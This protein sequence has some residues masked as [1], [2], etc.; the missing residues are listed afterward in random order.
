ME[1]ENFPP[2][3]YSALGKKIMSIHFNKKSEISSFSVNDLNNFVGADRKLVINDSNSFWVHDILLIKHSKYFAELLGTNEKKPTKEEKVRINGTNIIKTYIDVP[4]PEYFFDILTW[5]Y[6]KDPYR[7]SNAADEPESFLS[8]LSLGIFL[9]LCDEFFNSILTTCEI[10][11]DDKLIQNSQWSRFCF[12]FEVL[13]KL[14]E[15]MPKNNYLLKLCAT[16]SW[17]K[18]DNTL[19]I[20]NE[21][22][23]IEER[24]LE[25]LTCKEFFMVKDYLKEHKFLD[26]IKMTDISI[27]KEKYPKLLPALDL[28]YLIKRYIEG[29]IIKISCK[30]CNKK[31][32][33]IAQFIN[34]PC[35][36]KMYHPRNFVFLQ[37]Q[38]GSKC[39]HEDCKKKMSINE[40]PC[41]HKASHVDGC[42]MSDGN[43]ML[44][45]E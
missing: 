44:I 27:I 45:F 10:Q 30:I 42:L 29:N 15:L 26:V 25:L 20:S 2:Q 22:D 1:E 6:S 38:L 16:L 19:N 35:D 8:I 32:N 4:H 28:D 43:H 13:V 5:I 21:N 11:L 24:E 12:T 36:I 41:C 17:L 37:R 34:C 33:N 14:I 3:D 39:E 40:F 9:E 7:L 18:E 23:S 31:A